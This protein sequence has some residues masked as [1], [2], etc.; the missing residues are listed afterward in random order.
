MSRYPIVKLGNLFP[1]RDTMSSTFPSPEWLDI[2]RDKLNSDERYARVAKNWEGDLLIL[3]KPAGD[4]KEQVIIYFDL[5]HG[6]CRKVVY[7]GRL[8]DFTPAF[9]LTATYDNIVLILKGKLDAT[10][11]MLTNKLHVKGSMGYM[12]RNVPVVLDFVRCARE[13]TKDIL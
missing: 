4:L 6:K 11:A 13:V 8:E 12:M 1:Q 9:T 7:D 10:T 5:W 3:I 2:L